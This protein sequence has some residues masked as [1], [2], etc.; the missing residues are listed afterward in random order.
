MRTRDAA[1]PGEAGRTTAPPPRRHRVPKR[2]PPIAGAETTGAAG[3][4]QARRAQLIGDQEDSTVV[5]ATGGAARCSHQLRLSR[6]RRERPE[7]RGH[8][9]AVEGDDRRPRAAVCRRPP[10]RAR[11]PAAGGAAPR[12]PSACPAGRPAPHDRR[13]PGR[14]SARPGR[15]PPSG[16]RPPGAAGARPARRQAGRAGAIGPARA[17]NVPASISRLRSASNTSTAASVR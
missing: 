2:G 3:V 12:R 14:G 1:P 13:R 4:G 11:R 7:G 17:A 16:G 8:A 10:R 9:L 15:S 6:K 5:R